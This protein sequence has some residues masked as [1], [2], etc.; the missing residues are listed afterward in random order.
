MSG[1][2]TLGE[3]AVASEFGAGAIGATVAEVGAGA[4]GL[5]G[6][7]LA[8]DAMASEFGA[9]AIGQS[10]VDVG[11]QT[12]AYLTNAA[13]DIIDAASGDMVQS[14]SDLA[15]SNAANP[16]ASNSLTQAGT[17]AFAK[18]STGFVDTLGGTGAY[19]A[20]A[21]GAS[22]A[23]A[24]ASA[25]GLPSWVSPAVQAA[26]N[27]GQSMVTAN[28]ARTAASKMAAADAAAGKE[29]LAIYDKQ[30]ALQAPWVQAGQ[31]A[32]TQLEQ[33]TAEGGRFNRPFSLA[34]MQSSAINP[35]YQFTKDEAL[36]AMKNQAAAGGQNLSVNTLEGAGKLSG[37][38]ASQFE[39]QAF[40]Q[41]QM[42]NQS[43]EVALENLAKSGQSATN[44]TQVAGQAYITGQTPLT[45]GAGNVSAAGDLVASNA[46]TKGVG[47]AINTVASSP[48]IMNSLA[49]IFN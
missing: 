36:A 4:G 16:L 12:G 37:N 34:D 35:T 21:A 23:G 15:A 32:L 44:N 8:A 38:I 3:L 31:T 41:Y 39:N 13:G 14:A 30:Q 11:L 2:A 47:G 26:S 10:A 42:S 22:T 33:G 9:G 48:Q 5:I 28:A 40:N 20:D 27:I 43:A 49:S 46:L 45:V 19:G 24:A 29:N 6:S 18:G 17:D 1:A 7:G 25:S